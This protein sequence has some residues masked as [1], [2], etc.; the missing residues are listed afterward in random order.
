MGTQ[1]HD[2][3]R[4][5]SR[6]TFPSHH[7][8]VGASFNFGH[9]NAGDLLVFKLKVLTTGDIFYSNSAL[10]SDGKNHVYSTSYDGTGLNSL[11]PAGTYVAFEDLLNGG[12]FN[13]FDDTF[14]FTNVS[15]NNTV[16]E[17][18]TFAIW[19]L[20]AG[21][22]GMIWTKRRKATSPA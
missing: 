2:R 6:W 10:N 9:A 19:T 18:S 22:I 20:L 21:S 15:Q 11:M 13:Y 16:P 1:C 14:V 17:P 12:D 8:A 7:P 4:L 5:G 3:A